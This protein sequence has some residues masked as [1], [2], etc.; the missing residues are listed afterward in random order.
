[1]KRGIGF[2]ILIVLVVL[3]VFAGC[4]GCNTY[5]NMVTKREAVTG[6]WQQVEVAYQRRA[7]LIPNL[8]NTVKGAANFERGTLTDVV[9]ARAKATQMTVD[10]DDLTPENIARFEQAQGSLGNAIG[11]LLMVTENY[12]QLRATENFTALMTQLEGTENRISEQRRT[13]NDMARDYNTYVQKFPAKIW[14]GLFDF[15]KVG[16]FQG[17][18]GSEKAPTVNFE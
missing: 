14:A 18:E 6:Q 17:A 15:D 11:R 1:M 13:Y 10:P 2:W 7:D 12:P 4:G 5:N 16:Y 3:V 9:E 8:V